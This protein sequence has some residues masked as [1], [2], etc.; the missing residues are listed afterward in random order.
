MAQCAVEKPTHFQ[1]EKH[2]YRVEERLASAE[3]IFKILVDAVQDYAI[4]AL[5]PN[6]KILTWN[7]G[8]QR[9]KGYQ[10]DEIIG[11]TFHKFYSKE[12][13]ARKH[14]EFELYQAAKNGKYEEEGWRYRKDGTKFW[15]NVVITALRN[16]DGNL[17]GFG[18]VTRDLT[19]KKAHEEKLR[20]TY[21]EIEKRVEERTRELQEAKLNAENAVKARDQFFSIA[22]HELKTPIYALK[23]QTQLRRRKVERGD[24]S[25]FAPQNLPTLLEDE[26]RQV[27]RLEFLAENMLDISRLTS[28]NFSLN[29]E[30]FDLSQLMASV[31]VR[32]QPILNETKNKIIFQRP[33]PIVGNWDKHRLEQVF[34]NILIN[35]GKYAP[36]SAV[37]I[38]IGTEGSR[39]LISFQ[40]YGPGIPKSEQERSFV[41]FERLGTKTRIG[42]LGLGLFIVKQIIE[43]HHG[44]VKVI[45]E[46][47]EGA[48]FVLD[49]P[50]PNQEQRNG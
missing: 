37:N 43:A 27:N 40:D 25:D 19:E 15:A 2:L 16:P 46:A 18:K 22:S 17:R 41:A 32:M 5:D 4:F 6:G 42:G 10:A 3:E 33:E 11:C 44:T 36:E 35:A 50:I 14:P 47:G 23:L 24:L 45:S 39:V 20:E 28:G 9:L 1:T 48:N 21:S 38:K 29:R 7:Q 31:I 30:K 34:V 49:L 12:D 13:I 8:A 26:E